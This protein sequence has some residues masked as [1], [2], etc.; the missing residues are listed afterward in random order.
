MTVTLT[1]AGFPIRG[2]IA[3]I[4][5]RYAA[6]RMTADGVAQYGRMLLSPDKHAWSYACM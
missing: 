5:C 3:A 1:M 2:R 6:S 4:V